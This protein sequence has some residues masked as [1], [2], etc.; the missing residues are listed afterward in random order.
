[1]TDHTRTEKT[2]GDSIFM[3][4]VIQVEQ[5]TVMTAWRLHWGVLESQANILSYVVFIV[6]RMLNLSVVI[7]CIIVTHC[8]V[9]QLWHFILSCLNNCGVIYCFACE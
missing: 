2:G 1:M 7:I 9:F 8:L 3:F 6:I 4:M 5:E